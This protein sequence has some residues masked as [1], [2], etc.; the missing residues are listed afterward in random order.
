MA[1]TELPCLA[2]TTMKERNLPR[3]DGK[4][5]IDLVRSAAAPPEGVSLVT[6]KFLRRSLARENERA[7]SVLQRQIVGSYYGTDMTFSA[8][9]NY[10][11]RNI[12]RTNFFRAMEKLWQSLPPETRVKFPK[13]EIRLLKEQDSSQTREEQDQEKLFYGEGVRIKEEP[14]ATRVYEMSSGEPKKRS[15][16]LKGRKKAESHKKIGKRIVNV[17]EDLEGKEKMK[18]AVDKKLKPRQKEINA[19]ISASQKK[20]W[21]E[22]KRATSSQD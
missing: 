16:A 12:L 13:K 9:G 21:Q 15:V 17:G 8:Y 14:K 20:R 5:E 11:S 2:Q 4:L 18:K 10:L 1:E 22:R 3:G 6:Y 7:L 19:K